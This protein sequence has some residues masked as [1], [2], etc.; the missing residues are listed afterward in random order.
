MESWQPI[1]PITIDRSYLQECSDGD[2]A[3]EQEL[4]HLFVDDTQQHLVSLRAAIAT[5]NFDIARQEAHHIKGASAH[6]GA[7]TMFAIA[8]AVEA[9]MKENT[10][11]LSL[12]LLSQLEA[13]YQ[14]VVAQTKQWDQEPTILS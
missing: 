4:L 2:P 9:Q 12:P 7:V 8:A 10:T 6:V 1:P 14:D 5:Q 11:P 13:A 3:F